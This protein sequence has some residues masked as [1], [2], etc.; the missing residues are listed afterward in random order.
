MLPIYQSVV[1]DT[2]RWP[3]LWTL[4]L[5]EKASGYLCIL[6]V[7]SWLLS[8]IVLWRAFRFTGFTPRVAQSTASHS[9]GLAVSPS[10]ACTAFVDVMGNQYGLLGLLRITNYYLSWP[11]CSI[12][13]L[14]IVLYE[15]GPS[16][17]RAFAKVQ[18]FLYDDLRWFRVFSPFLWILL[19][20][21]MSYGWTEYFMQ[22]YIDTSTLG[23]GQIVATTVWIPA[24][25][26]F[27]WL[28][29]SL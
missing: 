11:W 1:L 16:Q 29:M 26:E 22:G 25:A 18:K 28:E 23:F 13:I 12:H 14:W 19:F 24:L 4:S 9:C 27:L 21:L 10:A 17:P 15:L 6:S 2:A 5:C 20:T 3:L 7:L 8:T